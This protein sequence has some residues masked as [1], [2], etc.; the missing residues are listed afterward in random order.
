MTDNKVIKRMRPDDPHMAE[1]EAIEAMIPVEPLADDPDGGYKIVDSSDLPSAESSVAQATGYSHVGTHAVQPPQGAAAAEAIAK[2]QEQINELQTEVGRVRALPRQDGKEPTGKGQ[3]GLPWTYYK[4]PDGWVTCA[5]GGAASTGSYSGIRAQTAFDSYIK[6]GFKH[7]YQYGDGSI[8]EPP[9]GTRRFGPGHEFV[10]LLN[11]GG[12]KEF[13]VE[14]VLAY[15]WHIRPP[16]PGV[17]F[18][19][20]EVAK[21]HVL[22]FECPDDCN[23]DLFALDTD[24]KS[25]RTALTHLRQQKNDGRHAYPRREAM[26]ALEDQGFP[27]Q[28]RWKAETQAEPLPGEGAP[29]LQSTEGVE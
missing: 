13:P 19:T 14:Q 4:K 12:A 24:V 6:K 2:M 11:A 20:Y 8:T 1:K 9:G 27:R 29:M 17:T 3:S 16:V 18:P 28:E 5:P 22:H 25:Q 26:A 23:F 21:D 15:K 10:R 7:L